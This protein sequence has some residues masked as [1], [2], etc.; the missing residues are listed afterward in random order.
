VNSYGDHRIGMAMGIA[1]LLAK[2][3]TV[4]NGAEAVGASYP[5]FWDT[6]DSLKK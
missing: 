2:G 4:V 1:G 3:E 6:L 5:R